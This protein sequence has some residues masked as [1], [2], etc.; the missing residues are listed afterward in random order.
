MNPDD[1]TD[2]D[3]HTA[4]ELG[5]CGGDCVECQSERQER[6]EERQM[7]FGDSDYPEELD[8]P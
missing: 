3:W 5:A 6:Q 1:W 8:V 7:E 4:H 2:D